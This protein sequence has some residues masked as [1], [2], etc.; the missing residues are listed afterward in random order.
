MPFACG[1]FRCF[2]IFP[3]LYGQIGCSCETDTFVIVNRIARLTLNYGY[4]NIE[5]R[6]LWSEQ[7]ELQKA[8]SLFR[9]HNS[10]LFDIF[11][12]FMQQMENEEKRRD[13]FGLTHG[14]YLI[15][16]YLIDNHNIKVIDFDDCEYSWYAADI[17]ICMRCYLF[18]TEHPEELPMKSKE[19]EMMHYNL[20]YGYNFENKITK[21]MVYDLDKYFKIRD[22]IELAQLL[23]QD[24]LNDIEKILY[25]ICL[26]RIVNRKPFL[27][28]NTE[29][30]Q[31]LLH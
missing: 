18:L 29:Q 6:G 8:G 31:K 30:A 20:L 24:E 2:Q 15:S 23:G 22:F 17:A 12:E 11:A 14:D 7:Q 4:I 26:D 21:E 13:N 5:K 16:N 25:D 9:I 1:R 27:N 19:A 28:F 10:V 3:E